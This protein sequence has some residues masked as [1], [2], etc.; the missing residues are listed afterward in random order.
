[1]GIGSASRASP[2]RSSTSRATCTGYLKDPGTGQTV[3]S[4]LDEA[5]LESIAEATGGEYF[6]R[7]ARCRHAEVAARIDRLQ[8]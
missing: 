1:M 7:A 8:K 4:R 3:L 5:G 2:S 6:H